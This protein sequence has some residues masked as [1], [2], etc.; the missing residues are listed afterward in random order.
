[1][2]MVHACICIRT[3]SQL[4][5]QFE[6]GTEEAPPIRQEQPAVSKQGVEEDDD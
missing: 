1:M 4:H 2:D 3:V 6:D 5:L